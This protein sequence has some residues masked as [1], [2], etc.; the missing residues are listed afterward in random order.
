MVSPPMDVAMTSAAA[1]LRF[2]VAS[3]MSVRSLDGRPMPASQPARSPTTRMIARP[4]KTQVPIEPITS[5]Q[6]SKR[7]LP[8]PRSSPMRGRVAGPADPVVGELR[9]AGAH[10]GARGRAG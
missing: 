10:E 1:M 9:V 7:A 3:P 2:A 8:I 6:V 4:T 5:R